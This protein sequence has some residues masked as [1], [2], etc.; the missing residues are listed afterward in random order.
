VRDWEPPI[1]LFT[2][3][4]GLAATARLIREA[5][6]ILEPGGLLAVEVDSR[7]APL[8]A[9][10]AHADARYRDVAVRLDL[11]GRARILL[12]TRTDG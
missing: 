9:E 5:A 8:A 4:R 3:D 6:S 12:A 2:G 11:T 1:A 10:L 7:R